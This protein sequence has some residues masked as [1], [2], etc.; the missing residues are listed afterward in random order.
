MKY[1]IPI[2]FFCFCIS[3]F[4]Q[5]HPIPCTKDYI[6][7]VKGKWIN[8]HENVGDIT[9]SQK[10]EAYKRLDI[11]HTILLKM[12]P[13]PTGVDVRLYRSAGICL[14]GSARKYR[15]TNDDRLTFDYMKFLP[16]KAYSYFANFSPHYCA[17]TS[18]GIIFQSGVTNENSDGIA[19]TINDFAGLAGDPSIDDDWLINSLPVRM[20]NTTVNEKWKGYVVYGDVRLNG[21]SIL[22]HREG[23]LPYIPVTRKQYL[24][25][26]ITVTTKL[27]DNI[28]E[29]QKKM[30]V[31]SMGEQ[32]SE[33]KVKLEK[34]EK[35]YGKDPK[36]LK[37]AVDYYLSGYKTDQQ[38]RDEEVEKAV[39]IRATELKKFNDELEK[40]TKEGL[41]DSPAFIR[42]MYISDLI[43]DNDPL[44]GSM[45]V[46]DNPDYIRKDLPAHVPQFIVFT[47]KWNPEFYAAHKPYEK[48]FLETF[49]IEKIQVMIDR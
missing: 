4:C 14:Y 12:Y 17:H 49:P 29:L 16:I 13:E 36:R 32:E 47:W 35:D 11:L 1:V 9:P 46:T 26:C 25:R 28:I 45:L 33:K 19:I 10:Q 31:R 20:F 38:I 48:L 5:N 41:L 21:R 15:L 2:I 24:E 44:T 30:P 7:T 6:V 39:K 23:M 18:E 27:H 42:V 22:I 34:F 40:T 37:S 3:A 43:F 8:R